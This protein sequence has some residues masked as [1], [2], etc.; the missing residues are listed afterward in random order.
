MTRGLGKHHPAER[1]HDRGH[2]SPRWAERLFHI[3]IHGTGK[4]RATD[5]RV[6]LSPGAS[7]RI[8]DART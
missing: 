8:R 3:V 7:R 5:I 2:P 1:D 6:S 4:P